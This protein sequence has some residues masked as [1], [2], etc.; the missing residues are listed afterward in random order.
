MLLG[1]YSY[2]GVV[3]VWPKNI[4]PG[5]VSLCCTRSCQILPPQPNK[6]V[7]IDFSTFPR[8]KNFPTRSFS[9]WERE[10]SD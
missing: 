10:L 2:F 4:I 6:H 5:V 1:R 9:K 3:L 7:A 8:T